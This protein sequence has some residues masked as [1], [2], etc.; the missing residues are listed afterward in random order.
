M[1]D[2]W[3]VHHEESQRVMESFVMRVESFLGTNRTNINLADTW[4]RTRPVGTDESISKYFHHAFD[5]SANRD[6]W[7]G[8]LKPFITEYTEK[9]GKPPILNPQVRFKV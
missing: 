5:W 4:K 2:Y 7:T 1:T 9:M 6:Q 3:P 8:L